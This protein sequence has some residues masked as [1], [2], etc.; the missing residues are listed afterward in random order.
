[1][2][3]HPNYHALHLKTSS[4]E[5]VSLLST[6]LQDAIL[7]VTA[8]HYHPKTHVFF[9]LANRFCWEAVEKCGNGPYYRVHCAVRIEN[10]ISVHKQ[11]FTQ[12]GLVRTLSLLSIQAEEKELLFTFAGG[13]ALRVNIGE[14]C[15]SLHDMSTPWTTANKPQHPNVS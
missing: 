3:D 9:F 11:G 6:L 12:H 1:M 10:V 15:M 2:H 4:K 7:S 5:E 13:Y 8:L 14:V